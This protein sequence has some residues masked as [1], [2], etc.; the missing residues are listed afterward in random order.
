MM[1]HTLL[2]TLGAATIYIYIYIR[3]LGKKIREIIYTI[4]H[5]KGMVLPTCIVL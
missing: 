2:S 4:M 3:G 5:K 1:K